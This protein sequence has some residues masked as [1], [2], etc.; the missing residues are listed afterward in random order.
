M[1][2]LI[3]KNLWSR[4]GR[5]I[6][7]I[8]E[9]ILVT[10]VSW[11]VLDPV[12]VRYYVK[13]LDPGYDIDRL[14]EI[15]ISEISEKSPD[16]IQDEDA[17]DSRANVLRLLEQVRRFPGV[18]SATVAFM[19]RPEGPSISVNS[20]YSDSTQPPGIMFQVNFEPGTD[21]FTT[22]GIR[23]ADGEG[24]FEEVPLSDGQAIVTRS[25]AEIVHGDENPIGRSYSEG[26]PWYSEGRDVIM[27]L[28]GEVIYRNS[29]AR[30]PLFFRPAYPDQYGYSELVVRM[31][32]GVSP[33]RFLADISEFA[34]STL[35]SGNFKA[36]APHPYTDSRD[37]NAVTSDNM[38]VRL[39]SIA[40]FFFIN[41]CLGILGTFYMQ[42][43]KR[44]RDVGV[45]R[46]FGATPGF[47]LR[48][49]LAE[50]WVLTIFSWAV[51]CFAYWLYI[52]GERLER[53]RFPYISPEFFDYHLT[54]WF[55]RFNEHFAIVSL[56]ILAILL[57]VVSVGILIPGRR[58]V[59]AN[60]GDTLH[61]E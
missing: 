6:W 25:V 37:N 56:I 9:L 31:A 46:A 20:I 24:I 48:E 29:L 59:S 22:F 27:G 42:T 15:P 19:G 30:T 40:V 55:D 3:F 12:I 28:C 33:M 26:A 45:M 1:L 23:S 38:L 61:E 2:K 32:P 47:C 10:V 8:F 16:Y 21:F 44:A 49:M 54:M 14:I 17:A 7:L 5:N 60:P 11:V 57:V 34:N 39:T 4:R 43:R 50:G 53:P 52:R 36:Q 18:E 58:I 35:R 41:L 13:N 51:G